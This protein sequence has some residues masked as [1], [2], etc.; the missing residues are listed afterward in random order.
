M[1]TTA[2]TR[3]PIVAGASPYRGLMPYEEEDAP[4]FFGRDAERKIIAANLVAARL[5]LLYGESGVGKSSVLRAGVVRHL[6][7]VAE[8]EWADERRADSRACGTPSSARTGASCSRPAVG[9][10]ACGTR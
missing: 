10:L 1:T 7:E 4:F 6:N 8:S 5:T 2:P 3:P 9:G